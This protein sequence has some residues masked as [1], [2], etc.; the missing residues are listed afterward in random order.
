MAE[1][2]GSWIRGQN[3]GAAEDGCQK[4]VVLGNNFLFK[5]ENFIS[6]ML[7]AVKFSN[8]TTLFPGVLMEA[9]IFCE[10]IL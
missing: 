8:W 5:E 7:A 4:A 6:G 9:E 3:A 2:G 10:K 1:G